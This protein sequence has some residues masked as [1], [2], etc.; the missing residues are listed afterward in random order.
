LSSKNV[1]VIGY[2]NSLKRVNEL[3]KYVDINREYSQSKLHGLKNI[4][5]TSKVTDI[6]KANV[7]NNC[8]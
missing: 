2:D 8:P 6:A 3:K 1:E 7:Y 5:F 4:G